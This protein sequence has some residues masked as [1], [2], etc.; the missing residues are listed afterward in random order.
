MKGVTV[1]VAL[2]R[3]KKC[4]KPTKREKVNSELILLFST[5]IV[6][7][8]I[9]RD[10]T[11]K[12]IECITNIPMER[13]K[14]E[15]TSDGITKQSYQPNVAGRQSECFDILN[16]TK[17]KE[18]LKDIKTF[19][20]HELKKYL[21]EIEGVDTNLATLQITQSWLSKLKPQEYHDLHNHKNSHL[22][23]SL[24]ISCLPNDYI[25]FRDRYRNF[26][27]GLEFPKKKV[28]QFKAEGVMVHIKKGDFIIFPSWVP[29][30]VGLN[31]TKDKDRIS[32]SFDTWPTYL[33][34]LY[35]PFN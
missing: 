24:Y 18:E 13:N 29:H 6:R 32:L 7:T 33:P 19:C 2:Q 15:L 23:G 9:G 1:A 22:S 34:S 27:I 30:Q 28:T 10:F 20:E 3:L 35:P 8:N 31:E 17:T 5:P 26:D 4:V 14:G 11:K 21:E 16:D 12:E 25:Q